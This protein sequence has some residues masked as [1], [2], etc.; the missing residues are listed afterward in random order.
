MG[1]LLRQ[2]CYGLTGVPFKPV[3]VL[4]YVC[5]SHS[6]CPLCKLCCRQ[7][8]F[9][10]Y[11]ARQL[12]WKLSFGTNFIRLVTTSRSGSICFWKLM[13]WSIFFVK[14][15]NLCSGWCG[16][17]ILI[18]KILFLQLLHGFKLFHLVSD[19]QNCFCF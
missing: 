4:Q 9:C 13:F 12:S 14:Y 5:K 19:F 3:E 6:G 16:R 18:Q 11:H 17:V 8:F 15:K 7:L 1:A 2:S 10:K